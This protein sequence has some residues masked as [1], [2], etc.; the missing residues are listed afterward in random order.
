MMFPIFPPFTKLQ[1]DSES[2]V[3]LYFRI[4]ML[5]NSGRCARAWMISNNSGWGTG[6]KEL[7]QHYTSSPRL[8][9]GTA[10]KLEV[11]VL[12]LKKT[13]N[14]VGTGGATVRIDSDSTI[15][16]VPAEDSRAPDS[17]PRA[18]TGLTTFR[19]AC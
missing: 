13:S 5:R 1:T 17:P 18:C 14:T 9:A 6:T 15:E 10:L 2:L 4:P 3:A 11:I 12:G 8:A 19:Q 7:M 16:G